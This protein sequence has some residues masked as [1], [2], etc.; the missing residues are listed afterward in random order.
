M[1]K[2]HTTYENYLSN[3]LAQ[4][5]NQRSKS[6]RKQWLKFNY[7]SYLPKNLDSKI[8]EIGPGYGE[9]LDYLVND[10]GYKNTKA[11]DLSQEVVDFCNQFI[12]DST[13]KVDDS[14]EFLNNHKNHFETVFMFH[15]LE[16]V[17]KTET[18]NL[19]SKIYNSL[20]KSGILIIEVPNMANP[21]TGINLRYT[22][23][24]HEVGFTDVSLRYVLQRAGFT[25]ISI[26]PTKVP[27]ISLPRLLQVIL[28]GISNQL[29][30]FIRRIYMPG[31]AQI[32]SQYIYAVVIK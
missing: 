14:D 30:N 24:T 28:Q 12:P 20:E 27:I 10:L 22:D 17:P 1:S 23:F 11:I 3:H 18:I 29:F 26:H 5:S 21:V 13:I 2:T 9:L 19:L 15:V 31:Q 7:T 8:L 16:H 4:V 32:M 25:N 6:N